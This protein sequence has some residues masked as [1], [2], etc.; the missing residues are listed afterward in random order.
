MPDWHEQLAILQKIERKAKS[1]LSQMF[2]NLRRGYLKNLHDLTARNIIIYY[3][4]WL[5]K[6]EAKHLHIE[7]ADKGG[8]MT[9]IH[10]MDVKKGLDLVLHTP[11]G[12]ISATE[13]LVDYLRSIFGTNIRAIVPELAMSAGTMIACACKK[14]IMG[15]QS[16]LGPIDPQTSVPMP[17]S[18][19]FRRVSAHGIINEFK[20]ARKD[21]TSDPRTVPLWQPII[22]QYNPT[23]IGQCENTISTVPD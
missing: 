18:G 1:D 14:I 11:G 17:G 7:D 3:S 21:I 8:F 2:D 9:C 12:D 15:K 22:C 20:K 4:G 13:S 16:S 19:K 6:P 23:L 5:H 10:G